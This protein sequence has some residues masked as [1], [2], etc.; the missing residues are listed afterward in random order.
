M[1]VLRGHESDIRR[2]LGAYRPQATTHEAPNHA[3]T[4]LPDK[5]I[6]RECGCPARSNVTGTPPRICCSQMNMQLW[7][8][9]NYVQYVHILSKE[10]TFQPSFSSPFIYNCTVV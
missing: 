7:W 6:S 8:R 3:Q 10:Y 2:L 4:S 9:R 5:V 1:S